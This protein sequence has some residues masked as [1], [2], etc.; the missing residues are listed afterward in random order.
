MLRQ[1]YPFMVSYVFSFVLYVLFSSFEENCSL[2]SNSL[3]KCNMV[4]LSNARFPER[5]FI[6]ISLTF[7]SL[8]C[9][10]ETDI[11]RAISCQV[12]RLLEDATSHL[13]VAEFCKNYGLPTDTALL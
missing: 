6:I 7:V 5:F 1:R 8:R 2:T 13:F 3:L 12:A 11:L 9:D 10:P 4:L